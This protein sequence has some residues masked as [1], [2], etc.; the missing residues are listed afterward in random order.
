MKMCASLLGAVGLPLVVAQ[1]GQP[2]P[3][4]MH[5][6]H[7]A[8][9]EL[10]SSKLQVIHSKSS[11]GPC[12]APSWTAE[13]M[14][15]FPIGGFGQG[16]GTYSY[17]R[18]QQRWRAK[19]CLLSTL[20]HTDGDKIC[21]DR[22]AH[23]VSTKS[24]FGMNWTVGEGELAVCHVF[25][26]PYYDQFALFAL[27]VHKGTGIVAG[28]ACEVWEYR[29]ESQGKN[30]SGSAC[31]GSDGVPRQLN[32]TT[33][34]AFKLASSLNYTFSHARIGP[35][36]DEVFTPSE[37]CEH[38]YPMPLCPSSAEEA[39]LLYR[40]HSPLE[41][42]S[43]EERN[44]GDAL[45]DMAF[46]CDISGMDE[47][48]LVTLWSVRANSSWA[49]YSYCFFQHGKNL[50]NG[51]IGKHVGRESALGVGQNHAQGQC[52]VNDE[53]GSWYSF[54]ADGHCPQG[55]EIGNGGCTWSARPIRS[56]HTKC[57][58]NDRGLKESCASERGHAPMLK[59][60]AIFR[61]A[62]ET[63]DPAQGGCPEA[64][65]ASEDSLVERPASSIA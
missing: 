28:E 62:L 30:V 27:A 41:P 17:D 47:T 24:E 26:G 13:L 14:E 60:A 53:V 45:G 50:C 40:A 34:A 56:V 20:F 63:G 49:Q 21:I 5:I 38:Q 25:P 12:L 29:F 37:V 55:A 31:I 23:N 32:V 61:A 44:L 64:E 42:R 1:F 48:Q 39:L 51:H 35:L 54:P 4:E 36:S 11:E 19:T 58:L 3:L 57:I 2:S 10:T 8:L 59:S 65:K 46:F 9:A 18:A 33:D 52:S 15:F 6:V 22:L 16:R 43:L 7:D